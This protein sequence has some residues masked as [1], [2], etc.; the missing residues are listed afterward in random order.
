MA[1]EV[2]KLSIGDYDDIIGLWAAAG[3]PFKPKGRD[4]REMMAKEMA[5]PNSAFYGLFLGAK[6]IGVIIANFDGRRGWINRLAIDPD[7]RGQ[8]LGGMLIAVSENFLKAAGA[9]VMCALI[10]EIN[11]PSVSCFQNNGYSCEH[12]IKYFTKRPSPEA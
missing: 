7:F 4:S 10:E 9:V 1:H 5:N 11:Y 3:L 2:R 12:N 6:M 8:G